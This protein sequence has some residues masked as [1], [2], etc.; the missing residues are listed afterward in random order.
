MNSTLPLSMWYTAPCSS[1]PPLRAK[2]RTLSLFS[3]SALMV[4]RTFARVAA[5]ATAST[6]APAP[7]SVA[8]SF[9]A[10]TKASKCLSKAHAQALF[11]LPGAATASCVAPL[12]APHF[13]WPMTTSS[14]VPNAPVANSTL[15]T[16]LSSPLGH[17]F[18]AFRSTKISPGPASNM[19]STGQRESAHPRTTAIGFCPC[20][21]NAVSCSAHAARVDWPLVYLA[22]PSLSSRSASWAGTDGSRAVRISKLGASKSAMRGC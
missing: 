4:M 3:N 14:F 15:P 11:L 20:S 16:T 6:D 17:V 10:G 18:P 2:S 13:V 9:A 12:M 21:A 22:L 5:A 8:A 19:V 1:N 7:N